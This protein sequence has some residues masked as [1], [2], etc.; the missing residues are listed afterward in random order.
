MIDYINKNFKLLAVF[1]IV[2]IGIFGIIF[3]IRVVNSGST[4]IRSRAQ[5]PMSASSAIIKTNFGDIKIIFNHNAPNSVAT[6]IN[7]V[8]NG[9]YT[10]TRIHR[11]VKNLLIQGGDPLSKDATRTSEWGHGGFENVIRDEYSDT[12]TMEVGTV[13]LSNQGANTSGT[14]FFIL[15]KTAPWLV[16]QN[17]IIGKVD[18]GFDILYKIQDVPTNVIGVPQEDVVIVSVDII[19]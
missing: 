18:E 12:D 11:I 2:S 5:S 10:G 17:T 14:Q 1:L 7:N 6:F 19:R 16:G 15:T 8:E 3:T 4:D 13:A 9:T